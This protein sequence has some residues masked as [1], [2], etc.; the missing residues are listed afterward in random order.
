MGRVTQLVLVIA[1]VFLAS[2]VLFG[3]SGARP[4]GLVIALGPIA[5]VGSIWLLLFRRTGR[6]VE[7]GWGGRS[8]STVAT[9]SPRP[10]AVAIATPGAVRP[11]ATPTAVAVALGRF[12]ARKHASS[13]WFAVAIGLLVM[14]TV[15]FG[16]VWVGEGQHWRLGLAQTPIMAYP[17]IGM[18]VCAAHGSVT[19]ARRD[20]AAELLTSCP[21]T[22]SIR[23]NGQLRVAWVPALAIAVFVVVLAI[24]VRLHPA[25]AFGSIDANAIADVV[26]A[27]VLGACGV[28]LGVALGQWAPWRLTP[29]VALFVVL[30]AS[31]TL[32]GIGDPHWSNM[33]QLST[34]PRYPPHDL[35]FTDRPVWWHLAWIA[36]LGTLMVVIAMLRADRSR[37]TL[38]IA[39]LVVTAAGVSGVMVTRPI[40]EKSARHIAS[41]VAE[42]AAHQTCVA[43]TRIEVCSYADQ[44]QLG[45]IVLEAVA[46]VAAAAPE[47]TPGLVFRQF[48]DGQTEHLGPDVAA[49][50]AV[51]P[52]LVEGD[53]LS[54]AFEGA[55]NQLRAV[56]LRAG[57]RLAMPGVG[58][59]PAGRVPLVVAGQARGVVALWL[60]AQ[61]LP[62][63]DATRLIAI[64]YNVHDDGN[65]RLDA[66]DLGNQGLWPEPCDVGA[67]PVAWSQQDLAAAR[68]LLAL[69]P[70]EV[71]ALLGRNW[72]FV[73]DPGTTTDELMSLAAL[74]PVGPIDRVLTDAIG[75]G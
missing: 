34:W 56:R 42:P 44:E 59:E 7:L 1:G 20:G 27:V 64:S 45:D 35:T 73:T 68:Q 15:L 71:H 26:T 4:F 23:M 69:P 53:D 14:T 28:F 66:W 6:T 13:T 16:W 33:R 74:A 49:A 30:W 43:A 58:G 40:S 9:T 48:F 21:A 8:P 46:P 31:T 72:A 41:L 36:A 10:T 24:S 19:R 55:R 47:G 3:G 32:G 63:D 37:R 2:L 50:I 62:A 11:P 18:A 61:G 5:V 65:H 17:M 70:A 39:A 51:L 54:F 12:E 52:P 25:A 75:C 22:Q 29:V 57:I 67:A 60:A 38:T